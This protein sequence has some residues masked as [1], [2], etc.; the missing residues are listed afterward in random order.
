M[1]T[2][3]FINSEGLPTYEAKDIG[4]IF[5]KW[6]DYH[7]DRSI[8]ITGNDIYEYMQVVLKAVEQ[9]QP[10][11]AE[12]TT[13]I[14]HGM[15]KAAGGVKMSSRLGN[16]IMADDVL[17]AAVAANSKLNQQQDFNVALGAVKYAFLK[18]RIGADIAFNPAESVSLQGN[19][20]PYLQYALVRA[21][22]ILQKASNKHA[23]L[24][25]NLEDDERSLARKLS[26]FAA[27]AEQAAAELLPSHICTYLYELAQNFNRFYEKNRILDDP[28]ESLRLKLVEDYAKVLEEGLELLGIP[29]PERM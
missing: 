18:N 27:V 11:L 21:K 9:I 17:D 4:L 10:D 29:A 26:E 16:I 8:V 14:T 20:G 6:Q 7:F 2:R 12:K 13:H 25:G 22:S 24:D 3:V 23:L 1:H 5:K 15:V 19:S 28:R